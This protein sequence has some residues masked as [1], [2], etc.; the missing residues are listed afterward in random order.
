ML[1]LGLD[2]Q[3]VKQTCRRILPWRD[4]DEHAD[5]HRLLG[6][7]MSESK[8]PHDMTAAAA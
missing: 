4:A 7:S 8:C 2:R 1:E 6:G 5:G 3:D